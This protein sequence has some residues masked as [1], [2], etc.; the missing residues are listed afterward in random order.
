[1]HSEDVKLLMFR[2]LLALLRLVVQMQFV[3]NKEMLVLVYAS[4]IISEILMKVA[5]QNAWS[6][7]TVLQTWH[8]SK[9]NVKTLVITFVDA[10]PYVMLSTTPPRVYVRLV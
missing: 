3:K 9:I 4:Q 5:V 2:L 10:M 1:M 6:I 8:V 7:Q